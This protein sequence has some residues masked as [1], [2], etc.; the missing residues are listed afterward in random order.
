ME[1][2]EITVVS[3]LPREKSVTA[4]ERD[5]SINTDDPKSPASPLVGSFTHRT[6][7]VPLS[8]IG[9][10]GSGSIVQARPSYAGSTEASEAGLR[11][12]NV[13]ELLSIS[14]SLDSALRLN[15]VLQKRVQDRLQCLE[16]TL[17]RN[18]AKQKKLED[19]IL[20]AK[21]A[22]EYE[23]R[24]DG[25]SKLN[26]RISF[27]AVPYFK[28]RSWMPAPMNEDAKMKLNSGNIDLYV[29]RTRPWPTAEKETLDTVVRQV[30]R[31]QC[32]SRDEATYRD[33]ERKL[34]AAKS[35]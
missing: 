11:R 8:A 23:Q 15:M 24:N 2:I 32:I 20:N 34:S 25:S 28:N 9:S 12:D 19:N 18:S 17:E 5:L 33:L 30:W 31:E 29:T 3:D 16:I 10:E 6:P 27:F 1:E 21:Q 35:E 13:D 4:A 7:S 22:R 26:L 14:P